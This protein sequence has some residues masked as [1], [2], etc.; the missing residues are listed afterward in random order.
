MSIKDNDSLEEFFRKATRQ[1]DL[2]YN[3]ED[4]KK[5]ERML[6]AQQPVRP[7][8]WFSTHGRKVLVGLAVVAAVV[9]TWLLLPRGQTTDAV[10]TDT[11]AGVDSGIAVT[12]EEQ[13]DAQT[14][15]E[16]QLFESLAEDESKVRERVTPG[17]AQDDAQ[18]DRNTQPDRESMSR[19][20]AN[21]SVPVRPR[22]EIASASDVRDGNLPD[23]ER[24]ANADNR[25]D[26][27]E[28]LSSTPDI[29]NN[30]I[31]KDLSDVSG[32][33]HTQV[34]SGALA[35]RTVNATSD[36]EQVS[37]AQTQLADSASVEVSADALEAPAPQRSQFD[38]NRGRFSIAVVAAP[39]FSR[40]ARGGAMGT[41]DAMGAYLTYQVLPRWGITTGVL[42]TNKKY[43]GEGAEY[44]PPYGY[45]KALTNGIVPDRI[46]GTCSMYEVP[47]AV[48]FD[49]VSTRR[50][51]LF[52]S[53][54]M[55]SY[56]VRSEEYYYHFDTPNPG[57]VNGWTGKKPST[58]WFGIGTLSAGLD[59]KATRT[60]SLG[61]EPYFKLPLEGMGWADIDLYSTGVMF[62]AR[63]H[64]AKKA[65]KHPP[66]LQGP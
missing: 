22:N 50:T 8:G 30:D 3:E 6:D 63:Y 35:D 19:A 45:W 44:R 38:E 11:A 33:N 36:D 10:V 25:I 27:N 32:F 13:R 57:A 40:T 53:A 52:A 34:E 31:K 41:G 49:I 15:D 56:F 26:P 65:N 5:L 1:H 61:V 46:D 51:R 21:T 54:G 47:V 4:W 7:A 39:D 42:Y 2:E 14:Q 60:L 62:A 18:M 43:W 66:T 37:Q 28:D 48:T 29:G 16:V 59:F 20:Q 17:V 55:S 24:I 12:P 9:A 23:A 58:L 64:F